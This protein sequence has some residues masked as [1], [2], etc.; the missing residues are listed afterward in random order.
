MLPDAVRGVRHLDIVGRFNE[1]PDATQLPLHVL[2]LIL[3]GLQPLALFAANAVRLLVHH[4]QEATDVGVGEDVGANLADDQLLEPAGVEPGSIA[5]VLA[6]FHDRLAD[7]VGELSALGV[8]AAKRPVARLALD[9]SAEQIGAAN[10]AGVFDFGST[11]LHQPV[12]SAEPGLGDDCRE[13]LL[14]AHRLSVALAR[15][16]PDQGARVDLVP[17]DAMDSV[18]RPALAGGTGYAL[19]VEGLGDLQH[20]RTGLC[21]IEY[22]LDHCARVRIEF[23]LGALLASVLH[24][25]AVVAVGGPAADP[26]APGCGLSHPSGDLLGQILR[27]ELVHTFDDSLKE[28]AGGS[29]VGLLS[30][31]DHPDTLAPEHG[32]EGDSVLPLTSEPRKFPHENLPEGGIGL[33]GGIDH[34]AELGAVSDASA[35]GLVDVLPGH[36][37]A[38]LAGVVPERPELCGHGQVHVLAVAGHPGVEGCGCVAGDLFHQ[39]VL[40]GHSCSLL[41]TSARCR[42]WRRSHSCSS[43]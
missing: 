36:Q 17:E 24:H 21:H 12:H 8:L 35:L 14:H 7:V 2:K 41:R 5:G 27:V 28:L 22:A 39:C 1:V 16:A 3:Y 15:S 19:V 18:L 40:L 31:G 26:E 25:G 10:P 32:L 30:D 23:Q 29:V 13:R 33:T 43:M 34:F 4:L 37:V 38:V 42:R 11:S 6:V 20:P 9:Q